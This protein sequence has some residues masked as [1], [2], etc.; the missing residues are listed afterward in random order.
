ML[1]CRLAFGDSTLG[2]LNLCATEP[3]AFG[4]ESVPAAAL[5]RVAEREVA[6]DVVV[7]GATIGGPIA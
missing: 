2:S 7:R 3:G 4:P 5:A 6:A 1:S